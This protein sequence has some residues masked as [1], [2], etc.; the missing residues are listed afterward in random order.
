MRSKQSAQTRAYHDPT[1]LIP[2]IDFSLDNAYVYNDY[3]EKPNERHLLS[4]A[5]AIINALYKL[6][7]LAEEV[8]YFYKLLGGNTIINWYTGEEVH[9]RKQLKVQI[10]LPSAYRE[11]EEVAEETGK[12]MKIPK[13]M[14]V[15]FSLKVLMSGDYYH[16]NQLNYQG[17]METLKE[18]DPDAYIRAV[19]M[20][21]KL[22]L[23]SMNWNDKRPRI[24]KNPNVTPFFFGDEIPLAH[25]LDVNMSK[26]FPCNPNNVADP[27]LDPRTRVETQFPTLRKLYLHGYCGGEPLKAHVLWSHEAYPLG[28]LFDPQTLKALC[29]GG[30]QGSYKTAYATILKAIYGESMVSVSPH[31]V[32]GKF[33]IAL[34]GAI[35]VSI[36]EPSASNSKNYND[37]GLYKDAMKKI[38][39]GDGTLSIEGKGTNVCSVRNLCNV[40]I[41]TNHYNTGLLDAED[42][43]RFIL[44]AT[45][46]LGITKHGVLIVSDN[47]SFTEPQNAETK[48][49]VTLDEDD[50]VDMVKER[51]HEAYSQEVNQPNFVNEFARYL[52]DY[53]K[54]YDTSFIRSYV[55]PYDDAARAE[56]LNMTSSSCAEFFEDFLS[57]E[58]TP[59]TS[60][61]ECVLFE[62]APHGK[63]LPEGKKSY[64][65]F[66]SPF[67]VEYV[68]WFKTKY[69]DGKAMSEKFFRSELASWCNVNATRMSYHQDTNSKSN[70]IKDL[71]PG[72][73]GKETN[74]NTG[75][76]FVSAA[77][78][79]LNDLS[80]LPTYTPPPTHTPPQPAIQ[81]TPPDVPSPL[82]KKV[83]EFSNIIPADISSNDDRI[84]RME[85]MFLQQQMAHQKQMEEMQIAHQKQMAEMF[86]KLTC[87]PTPKQ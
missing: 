32:C 44:L 9:V 25:N 26:G 18:E 85:E 86:Q 77:A 55:Q 12:K 84:K 70:R 54:V 80:M 45:R 58:Y 16:L 57:V 48:E 64:Y 87:Y 61:S 14:K 52:L 7:E 17:L 42:K 82:P 49:P 72:A 69:Q 46:C 6:T 10:F 79:R 60:L 37:T 1:A 31:Q 19:Q 22:I 63:L 33:N 38:I 3:A 11:A 50:T 4:D 34:A 29:F 83:P 40:V 13:P 20:K 78:Y 28:H 73:K 68:A 21:E 8:A 24:P 47:E 56:M 62:R 2:S 36:D 30:P 41:S 35:M 53:G 67:Y 5:G 43:R 81:H 23:A 66:A 15:T 71:R 59:K 76:Q 39:A 65:I 74:L 51:F 27:T 75:V